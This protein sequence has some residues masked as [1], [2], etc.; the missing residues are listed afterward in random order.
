MPLPF[1]DAHAHLND[2]KFAGDLEQVVQRA[3]EAGVTRMINVGWDERSSALALAQADCFDG[4]FATAGLH[5]HDASKLNDTTLSFFD[6]LA[7]DEKVVA[8][9]ETGLDYHYMNSPKE[10]QLEAFNLHLDL[11]KHLHLPAVIHCREAYPELARVL[12]VH[13]HPGHAPWLVHCFSGDMEDLEALV[14]LDCYFSVGGAITFN[15][16]TGADI[17]RHIPENRLL[18]E[19]DCP[20]M[21][22]VPRRG[23]RNEPAWMVHTAEVLAGIREVSIEELSRITCENWERLFGVGAL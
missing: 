19:T 14:K 9:G 16:F 22:P 7:S 23:K 18:V 12:R 6:G 4:V 17:V 13:F 1:Y 3:A 10:T 2:E 21:A 11:A 15:K 8:I 20:Y 5:P